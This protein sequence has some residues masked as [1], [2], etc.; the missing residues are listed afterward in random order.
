MNKG[1]SRIEISMYFSNK[2]DW[3]NQ[4]QKQFLDGENFVSKTLLE[5]N[6]MKK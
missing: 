5:L 1:V 6:N 4:M 2:T 3:I